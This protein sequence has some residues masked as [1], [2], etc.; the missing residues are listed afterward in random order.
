[1]FVK[2]FMNNSSSFSQNQAAGRRLPKQKR[3]KERLEKILIAA[4]EVFTEVGYSAA[5]T[6]QIADRASTAIG[7]IY[8]FFPDK[9]AIFH[10]LEDSHYKR[11]LVLNQLIMDAD[12]HRPLL[13]LIDELIDD[14]TNFVA[15]PISRCVVF[16]LLQPHVPGLFMIF[17]PNNDN[18]KNLE[19]QSVSR[20][21]DFCQ[22]RNPNLSREKSELLSEVAHNVYRSLFFKAFKSNNPEHRKALFAELKDLLFGYF[23]P[24]IGDQ[25]IDK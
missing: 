2:N 15:H 5:T 11:L 24:H 16:Q 21:A 8:Q 10:A 3:G 4:A 9:L 12:I 19:Q 23:N 1:M 13:D 25:F 20:L 14:Y 6:Q 17:N 22:K 7:S 18:E